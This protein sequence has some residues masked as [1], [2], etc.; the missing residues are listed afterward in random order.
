MENQGIEKSVF[1]LYF[2]ARWVTPETSL[3]DHL[4][5]LMPWSPEN[6]GAPYSSEKY[7]DYEG[8]SGVDGK[9]EAFAILDGIMYHKNVSN[10]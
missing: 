7:T 3:F 8:G 10:S 9:G 6:R 4:F 2:V 1:G 5:A